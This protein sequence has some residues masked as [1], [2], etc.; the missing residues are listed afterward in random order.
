MQLQPAGP[1]LRTPDGRLTP[2]VFNPTPRPFA[3]LG[4]GGLPALSG[5]RSATTY[6]GPP[7]LPGPHPSLIFKLLHEERLTEGA[8]PLKLMLFDVLDAFCFGLE[9]GALTSTILC[10]LPP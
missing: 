10:S 1:P 9:L 2:D 6:G 3:G 8:S 4:A 5:P 7:L